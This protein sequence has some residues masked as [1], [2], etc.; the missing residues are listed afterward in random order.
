MKHNI[1]HSLDYDRYSE[2]ETQNRQYVGSI[3]AESLED[4]FKKTQNLNG[5]WNESKPCRSTSI[6]D[7]IENKEGFY[8][9]LSMGFKLLDQMSQNESELNSLENQSIEN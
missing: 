6:G 4:A 7:V 5:I 2:E 1:Y 3:D 9:V 8:L